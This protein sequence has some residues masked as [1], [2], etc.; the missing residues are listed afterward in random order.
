MR[1]ELVHRAND[2]VR[3]RFQLC[4]LAS[5][6]ARRMN[7]SSVSMQTTINRALEVISTQSA[8]FFIEPA[9]MSKLTPLR[10]KVVLEQPILRR[11]I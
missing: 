3:N 5:Y 1:S 8:V 2:K 4:C 9:P 7:Q 10:R 6:S 11:A